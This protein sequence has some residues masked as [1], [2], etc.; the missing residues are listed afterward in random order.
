MRKL[1]S[2]II[3][4]LGLGVSVAHA[5]Y[6]VPSV[7]D[8]FYREKPK[9]A[10]SFTVDRCYTFPGFILDEKPWFPDWDSVNYCKP[11]SSGKIL[12]DAYAEKANFNKHYVF[13]EHQYTFS[14]GSPTIDWF[15]IDKRNKKVAILPVQI[16]PKESFWGNENAHKLKFNLNS[17]KLCVQATHFTIKEPALDVEY[18]P[19]SEGN[20]CFWLKTD[21]KGP[22]W[23][24]WP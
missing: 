14:T 4:T 10:G 20:V 7:E 2:I 11:K 22:Y 1:T 16:T 9:K 23:S 3:A 24:E 15:A 17:N 13:H 19:D 6:A 18:E 8:D 21:K 12:N 5:S